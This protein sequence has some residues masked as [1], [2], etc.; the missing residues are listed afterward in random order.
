MAIPFYNQVDQDIYT[1]GEHFIP[2]Q[3]YRLNYTPSAMLASTVGN[4]GGVTNTSAAYPYIWPPQ[5]GGGGGGGGFSNTNKFGLDLD[6]MKTIDMGRYVEKG[7]PGNM[8]GGKYVKTDRQIA[9]D[10]HGNWK[11]VNTNQNVYHAN[12]HN[13]K[14]IVGTVGDWLTGKSKNRDTRIGTWT[15]AEW[16]DEFD[17]T[18]ANRDLNVYT[19]WKAKR[20][21]KAAQE[22]AAADKAAADAAAATGPRWRTEGGG[23]GTPGAGGENVRSSSGDVY[24]GEAYGYNEAAEKSDYYKHGGRIGYRWGESVD[25]EEPAEN[26]LEFMQDQGIPGG[27]MVEGGPTEEQRAMVIDMD[28]RGMGIDEIMSFTQLGKEDILNIL[29]I[30][31]ANG[32]IARLL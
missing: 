18:V 16:D 7:G 5:G 27:E 12:L 23:Q 6:T 19:R 3:H 31:R 21:F 14:G 17:P 1:G 25:P 9:Q 24:G 11:D 4:T 22:K 20:E 13:V 32:G 26:I 2:Q 15:G 30:E 8:Y 10:E 29:G 28:G